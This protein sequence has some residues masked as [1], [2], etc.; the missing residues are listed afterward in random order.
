MA[1]AR[2]I[3]LSGGIGSGKSTV[4]ALFV[5]LGAT[6]IDADAIVHELQAAGQP[7]LRE[8]AE[9]F[10]EKLIRD[11]GS[12]DRE[13]LGAIVFSDEAARAQLGQVVHPAVGAEMARRLAAAVASEAPLIVLDIPLLFEG[14]RTGSTGAS[15]L[16][17]D[18]TVLVWVP[19]E[20]QIERTVARDTCSRE[21]AERRVAAQ[22]PIDEKRDLADHVIDNSGSIEATE[23]ALR[24]LFAELTGGAAPP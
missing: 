16:D 2:I 4:A 6:L 22:M 9:A 10:G 21:E 7:L 1:H 20:I 14:R 3:G 24:L 8:I 23:A 18:A 5:Q 12:L 13:A 15:R 11:D 19:R 17:F